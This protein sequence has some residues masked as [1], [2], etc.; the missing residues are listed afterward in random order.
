MKMTTLAAVALLLMAPLPVLA[1]AREEAVLGAADQARE[2]AEAVEST[3]L[4]PVSYGKGIA[5][6]NRA[7]RDYRGGAKIDAVA[8]LADRA[9]QSFATASASAR[10]AQLT[11][12]APL[13]QREAARKA[14]AFRLAGSTWVK[15]E[16]LLRSAAQRLEK[17]DV[18]G[19]LDRG[20]RAG[21]LYDQ[22]ELLALKAAL[23]TEARRRV[24]GLDAA[25]TKKLAPKTTAR[26]QLLLQQ[27][28][29]QLDTD[30]TRTE[31]AAKLA[32]EAAAEANHAA[33][34][35]ALLRAA[36]EQDASSEDILREWEASL[37]QTGAAAA[38]PVD[39]SRGPREASAALAGSVGELRRGF[40]QQARDLRQRDLQI[41]ALE[42]ELRDLDSRLAGATQETR[43]LSERLAVRE[44]ARQ[45]AEQLEGL[46][47]KD[48]A[49]VLR[50]GDSIIVRVQGLAFASGSTGLPPSAGPLLEK[51]R[52]AVA[53]YP[54]ALC[55][56][57]GHTDSSGDSAA[58]QRLSQARAEAVR[59][60]LVDRLQVSAA[61]LTAIGY[62]D[63]RPI[64][65]NE[66]ADGRRQNRRI[67]LVIRPGENS[68]P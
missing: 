35:S 43:S 34:L 18:A 60:Y 45:Q 25:A 10:Q 11:L 27:A 46:F 22:A 9:R 55:A 42:E 44:R 47:P 65:K 68:S 31:A 39:F 7:R 30:R 63:S 67:D 61:R 53:V 29:A 1:D 57:E 37:T 4:A 59:D 33:A 56:I 8:A 13:A 17:T 62:G 41:G 20:E 49:L 40:D 54:R 36:R 24:V 51:L 12:Q 15:A 5:A 38:V 26:A 32:A 48:Q 6:L 58:N 2:Q 66:T 3:L 19:A 52:D 28:E 50:Q 23:L 21:Q 14:D 64:A 16:E